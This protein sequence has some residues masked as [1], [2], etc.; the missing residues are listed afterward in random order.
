MEMVLSTMLGVVVVS[1]LV[2][3]TLIR[4]LRMQSLRLLMAWPLLLDSLLL[5]L[6]S[7]LLRLQQQPL[8]PWPQ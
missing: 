2:V 6:L 3:H 5:R 8:Q 7:P 1:L 4:V